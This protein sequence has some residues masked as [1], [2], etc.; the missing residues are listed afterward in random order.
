M[1][2][3]PN[4]FETRSKLL[5]YHLSVHDVIFKPANRYPIVQTVSNGKRLHQQAKRQ[6]QVRASTNEEDG[7][8]LKIFQETKRSMQLADTPSIF[9]VCKIGRVL[10]NISRIVWIFRHGDNTVNVFEDGLTEAIVVRNIHVG[11]VIAI[12]LR[13]KLAR[14]SS[15]VTLS[16]ESRP[17]LVCEV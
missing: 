16:Q 14:F 8:Q 17:M 1:V 7:E 3:H 6:M 2:K 15:V 13:Q 11:E 5:V 10:L 12:D 9:W 4:V